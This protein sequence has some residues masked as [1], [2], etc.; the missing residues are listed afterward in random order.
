MLSSGLETSHGIR[1]IFSLGKLA[2]DNM[3]GNINDMIT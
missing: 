2:L 3:I 1:I